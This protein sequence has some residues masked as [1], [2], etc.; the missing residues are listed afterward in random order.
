MC[1]NFP[2]TFVVSAFRSYFFVWLHPI[3]KVHKGK[4]QKESNFA[5]IPTSF[6]NLT[7]VVHAQKHTCI[8]VHLSLPLVKSIMAG[9]SI[10]IQ[11]LFVLAAFVSGELRYGLDKLKF[12]VNQ[13]DFI[14]YLKAPPIFGNPSSPFPSSIGARGHRIIER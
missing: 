2:N 11:I 12:S 13:Q 14:A 7:K 1:V 5:S 9:L 10:Q 4:Q 6:H 3:F 8:L